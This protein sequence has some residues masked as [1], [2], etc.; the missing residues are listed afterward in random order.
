[1]ATAAKRWL[2]FAPMRVQ[3]R[4]ADINLNDISLRY[5]A[6]FSQIL[7]SAAAQCGYGSARKPRSIGPRLLGEWRQ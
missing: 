6:A 3:S 4:R 2:F 1:M 5:R 7:A